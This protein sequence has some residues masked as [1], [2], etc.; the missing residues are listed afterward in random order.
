MF[1]TEEV[2]NIV[3]RS[4]LETPQAART[5]LSGRVVRTKESIMSPFMDTHTP[6]RPKTASEGTESLPKVLLVGT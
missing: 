6:E 4:A 3:V 1:K 5:I 2:A